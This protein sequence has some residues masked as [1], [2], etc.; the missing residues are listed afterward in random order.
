MD[1]VDSANFVNALSRGY[2]I[3]N[4]RP[5]PPGYPVYVFLGWLI[6]AVLHD[7]L[8]SL[9]LLSAVLG[10]LAVVPFYLLARRMVDNSYA[11]VGSLLFLANPLIWSFSEAALSDVPALFIGLVVALLAFR[12]RRN[13]RA[14]L[15]SVVVLSL[16]IGL[17]VPNIALAV[18]PAWAI[19]FRIWT[20][21]HIPWRVLLV[22]GALFVVVTV[23]WA[24]PMV[25]IGADGIH[26]Y[27]DAVNRQWSSAVRIHGITHV[28][29]PAGANGIVRVLRFFVGYFLSTP[30]TGVDA[31]TPAAAWLSVPWVLG[32]A[33]FVTGFDR[34]NSAHWFLLL[35][36]GSI[37]YAIVTIHFL[38]RYV[39]A[40]L[41][42]FIIAA[43]LGYRALFAWAR[44]HPKRIEL[45]ASIGIATGL[46]MLGIKYQPPVDTFE[47]T[48]PASSY[49]G[50]LLVVGGFVVAWFA[51]KL[52]TSSESGAPAVPDVPEV[53]RS[54][55]AAQLMVIG[56]SATAIALTGAT[57]Y[58]FA[59][60]AHRSQ[61][62][63]E[64]LVEYV[65][66]NYDSGTSTV[67]WDNQTHSY[68]GVLAPGFVATGYWSFD[69]LD[70]A[71]TDGRLVILTDR[72][73]RFAELT[74]RAE[75]VEIGEFVGRSPVWSKA[76]TLRLFEAHAK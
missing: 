5:H 57:G 41:P 42:G 64:T 1:E 8:L 56:C 20:Q 51:R 55:R 69:E 74:D 60:A 48:P 10:S 22:S 31:R 17:R 14:L 9:T 3:P 71:L 7:P 11:I 65:K 34:K 72:C 27:V 37:L 13:D 67:C 30:W 53:S 46:I 18:L 28:G 24:T 43:L 29:A 25:L 58:T 12:G 73:K 59:A 38:P 40:Q 23:A 39:M 33:G 52:I 6:D 21:R 16:A 45:L 15:L 49:L 62:P 68:F 32:F 50:F 2:D 61:N 54:T 63:N 66:A 36:I 44:S 70:R 75:I 76:P 35:W 19:G 26:S 4:L 47:S